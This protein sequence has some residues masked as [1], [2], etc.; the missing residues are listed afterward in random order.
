MPTR[1]KWIKR[2]L[3]GI[4]LALLFYG[5]VLLI[6]I[7]MTYKL[8]P[9][10]IIDLASGQTT[11]LKQS[12]GRTNILLL[13]IGGGMHEGADLT[14]T[15]MVASVGLTNKDTVLL[16]VPRDIWLTNLKDKINAAYHI[17]ETK[18]AGGGLILAKSA[19]EEVVG[20]PIHY[21]LLIDFEGFKQVID[22]IGG[23]DVDVKEAF[24]DPFYPIAGK[25]NDL[26]DGDKEYLCRY[27]TVTFGLGVEHMD[28]DRALKYVRSRHAEGDAG[29][30]FSRGRRQQAV[31]LALKKRLLDKE[32]ITNI[33]L[34]KQF[35]TALDTATTTD[36]SLGEVMLAG[37]PFV[38]NQEQVRTSALIQDEPEKKITGLLVNPPQWQYDGKWVLIPK[39]GDFGQIGKYVDCVIENQTNCEELVK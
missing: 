34:L 3:V 17:G 30:D 16:S 9:G 29:T 31:M 2:I 11:R 27:E 18:I 38:L 5:L 19:V 20:I 37:R 14:D 15:I 35:A 24:S 32:I 25:E 26:C 33:K 7:S 12:Q 39:H 28:G 8:T 22:L 10:I 13:G 21:A 1:F 36:M 23:I 6:N 4:L